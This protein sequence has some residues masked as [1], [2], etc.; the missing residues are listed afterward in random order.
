MSGRHTHSACA[1]LDFGRPRI[2]S[3]SR[4][5]S[6]RTESGRPSRA[7]AREQ[8]L[9]GGCLEPGSRPSRGGR[10]R[11]TPFI[12]TPTR[13]RSKA[14]LAFE[15]IVRAAPQGEIGHGG[16][17]AGRERQDVVELASRF[18]AMVGRVLGQMQNPGAIAEERGAAFTQVQAACIDF[19][20]QGDESGGRAALVTRGAD[21]R[22]EQFTIG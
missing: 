10:R 8:R 12:A 13:P 16:W 17:T 4:T 15:A 3:Y 5:C 9:P 1:R 22:V 14:L 19:A 18:D 20:E 11:R 2:D 6:V 21:R 7:Q